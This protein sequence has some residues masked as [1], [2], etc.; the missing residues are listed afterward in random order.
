MKSKIVHSNPWF[1]ILKDEFKRYDGVQA[2]FYVVSK[3]P[4]V[5]ILPIAENKE[6]YLIKQFRHA[7]QTWGWE[8]PAGSTDKESPIKAAKRELKEE[9]GLTAK[10]WQFISTINL[11]PGLSDNITYIF[12]AKHLIQTFENEQ[13]EEGIVACEKFSIKKIK[14]MISSGEIHDAPTI[15]I[16]AKI[17]WIK[18][19]F[20][21]I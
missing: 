14:N 3:S 7:T 15:A 17:L 19:E 5:F 13:T 6:I 1:K 10:I 21:L 20:W 9:T 12:I 2:T 11:V 4:A 8:L 18:K 16:L